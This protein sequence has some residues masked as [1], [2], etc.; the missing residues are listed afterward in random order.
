MTDEEMVLT[1]VHVAEKKAKPVITPMSDEPD[2]LTYVCK[3][4]IHE[5]NANNNTG[6]LCVVCKGCIFGVC[7]D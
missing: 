5:Y 3:D 1:C 7:K 2:E 4:C 6:N